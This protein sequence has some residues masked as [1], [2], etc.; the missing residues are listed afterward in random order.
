MRPEPPTFVPS[1]G[2]DETFLCRAPSANRLKVTPADSKLPQLQSAGCDMRT[3]RLLSL[4]FFFGPLFI[5]PAF[6]QPITTGT[7]QGTVTD[8]TGASL[9]GVTVEAR[10][11]DTNQT[12]TVAT[13]S[14]GRYI[15]LQLPPGTYRVTFSLTGFA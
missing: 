9:P 5:H 2:G 11:Q 10:H 3:T 4:V 6:A 8:A 12:R 14:D 1:S 7:I 13:G 15:F